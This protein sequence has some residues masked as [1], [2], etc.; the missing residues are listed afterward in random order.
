MYGRINNIR[1]M[2]RTIFINLQSGQQLYF[3][4]SVTE[5][6]DVAQTLRRGDII[7]LNRFEEFNTRTGEH[8]LRIFNFEVLTRCQGEIPLIVADE[9]R[10]YNLIG[11]DIQRQN[12]VLNL[13]ANPSALNILRE[14]S[15]IITK[16]RH[17]L[18]DAGSME[19]ET[20]ILH[21][22]YGGASADPFITHHNTLDR[23]L[24]LR[25]S[26][27]LYLKRLIVGGLE[28]IYEISRCFRNEGIDRYH[29]PE[30]TLLEFYRGNSDWN[31]GI[32]FTEQLVSSILNIDIPF[33]RINYLESIQ[34]LGYDTNI[35]LPNELDEIFSNEIEPYLTVP[36][37]VCGHPISISPLAYSSDGTSAERFELYIGG[38]EIANGYS[39]Q[40]NS[41]LQREAMEN[42]GN[43]DEE[44]LQALSYGMVH[45]CG[46][47]IGIDRLVMLATD[48][49]NIRDVIS[50]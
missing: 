13:I 41:T 46:V 39:E 21:T 23:D 33:V 2:G 10:T 35:L 19:V 18:E 44:Y 15:R 43:V 22:K 31:W 32:E 7:Q 25:I 48:S 17:Q 40:N 12:R 38:M 3:S 45:T 11:V 49:G 4:I 50:F 16:I 5:N 34:E 9:E 29:N 30:F 6:F 42:L 24:F 14:R 27:E 26:P 28:F 36:T 8:T 1:D 37:F 20:P 47:G